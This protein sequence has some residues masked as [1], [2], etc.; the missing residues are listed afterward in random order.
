MPRSTLSWPLSVIALMLGV[1]AL[2]LASPT[3]APQA[4]GPQQYSDPYTTPA[5]TTP[6][7][8]QQATATTGSV[9]G[10]EASTSTPTASVTGTTSRAATATSAPAATNTNAPIATPTAEPGVDG[11]IACLPGQTIYIEGKGPPMTA[12][13]LF[14]DE[15]AVGG[16]T[17][18]GQGNYRLKLVVANEKTGTY[19]VQVRV[20]GTRQVL[21]ELV[22]GVQQNTPTPTRARRTTPP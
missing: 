17:S 10:A 15:T 5:T 13:L 16:G 9:S 8:S 6:T 7:A 1:V 2:V 3:Q 20:R 19:R 22:C 4:A 14:F 21:Q 11:A 18:D 12:L